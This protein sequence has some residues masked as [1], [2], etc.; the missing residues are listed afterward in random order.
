MADRAPRILLV[1]D[2]ES[3]QTLLSLSRCARTATRSCSQATAA[4]RSKRFDEASF[5]LVVLD[6]MM[7]VLDGL[8]VCKRLRARS[9]VPIIML[10]AKS[11]EVD[12]VVGLELG[13]D[14]YITKPFS[15]REF[16]SRVKAALRRAAITR[17]E[18]GRRRG[19]ARRSTS[20]ASTRRAAAV[21]RAR[22][23]R[24]PDLRGV[25][26]PRRRWRGARAASGRASSCSTGVWGDSAYR[27][28]RTVDVHIRHLR[29]KI[30]TRPARARVPLHRA[31]RR[32]PL[33]RPLA[34]LGRSSAEH[35]RQPPRADLPADHARRDRDRLRRRRAEP[36]LEPV[37]ERGDS[38]RSTA[39]RDAPAIARAITGGVTQRELDQVVRS[40]ADQA[41]ARVTLLSVG[42]EGLGSRPLV[43]SDSNARADIGDL[44]FPAAT[45]AVAG[46]GAPATG[47][48]AVAAGASCRPRGRCSS[49]TP[50]SGDR[51]LA[52]VV[53]YSAPLGDVERSVDARALADHHRGGRSRSAL[54]VLAAYAV[55]QLA[56]AAASRAFSTSPS[57]SRSATSRP[58]SRSTAT[59]S[60]AS[61]R[62]RS[63]RCSASSPRSTPR[64]GASSR[65]PRTS[66]ARRSSRSAASSSCSRTRTSTRRRARASSTRCATRPTRLRKLTTDLLDLS[67][68]DAASVELRLADTDVDELAQTVTERVP[69]RARA[70]TSRASA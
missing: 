12:K 44:D 1:D 40:A 60:S 20:C 22:R 4:R 33:P 66:C 50:K 38:L 25:R 65:P 18:A 55:A 30:E 23:G 43:R 59:T 8:E 16:R 29:E 28:P 42:A 63:T 54:A 27:D 68:L 21:Q 5:D 58:A 13:A 37:N 53:V 64:A 7:P 2:E 14:D 15:V 3:I 39:Q 9:T 57:A 36:A 69:A 10:T 47:T 34:G 41:N 6:V 32:L 31:R 48:E 19:A 26:D 70:S 35:A 24:P 49:A 67:R 51:T 11:D 62:R 17:E 46:A 45:E 61:S 56:R 52:F